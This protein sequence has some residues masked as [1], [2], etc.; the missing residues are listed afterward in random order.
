M[1]YIQ[2]KLH[3]VGEQQL[4]TLKVP[5]HLKIK[6]LKLNGSLSVRDGLF[7]FLHPKDSIFTYDAEIEFTYDNILYSFGAKNL[8]GKYFVKD[9]NDNLAYQQFVLK[10]TLDEV[11]EK[12]DKKPHSSKPKI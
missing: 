10:F 1:K 5:A 8:G 4:N 9:H 11:L 6:D 7:T 12:H 2:K 3:H